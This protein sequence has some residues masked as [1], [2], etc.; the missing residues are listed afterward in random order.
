MLLSSAAA[1]SFTAVCVCVCAHV[2]VHGH[3]SQT[4]QEYAASSH[5][6]VQPEINVLAPAQPV[7]RAQ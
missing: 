3:S 2:S 6:F 1:L 4:K 5:G 7:L